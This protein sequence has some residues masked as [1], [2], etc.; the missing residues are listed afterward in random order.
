MGDDSDEDEDEGADTGLD[1]EVDL[2]A[3]IDSGEDDEEEDDE[4][5]ARSTDARLVAPPCGR[6][7]AHQNPLADDDIYN[8]TV[9][10]GL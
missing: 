6:V 10:P 3:D 4:D 7:S 2:F 9:I 1:E 5:G 8:Q